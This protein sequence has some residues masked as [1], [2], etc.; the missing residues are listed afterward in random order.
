MAGTRAA[1]ARGGARGG[2]Q[3]RCER[4]AAVAYP[5]RAVARTV[6]ALLA[7]LP[8]LLQPTCLPPHALPHCCC[9]CTHVAARL[10]CTFT[11]SQREAR[12]WRRRQRARHAPDPSWWAGC[13]AAAPARTATCRAGR[14]GGWVGAPRGRPGCQNV[15]V[16]PVSA[17]V[18]CPP[19]PR[20]SRHTQP[21][22]SQRVG[23]QPHVCNR[24]AQ[25]HYCQRLGVGGWGVGGLPA[26]AP[27]PVHPPT[28]P[29]VGTCTMAAAS[30]SVASGQPKSRAQQTLAA[31]V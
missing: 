1:D 2:G 10:P 12:R 15:G 19:A 27:H 21:T 30:R 16:A 20:P 8:T 7:P 13:T 26:H 6:R 31:R 5:S 25:P 11:A 28:H 29:P 18:P 22:H 4:R 23:A 17:Q 24:G 14:G 3:P 9:C